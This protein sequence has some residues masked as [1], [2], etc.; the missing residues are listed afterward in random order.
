MTDQKYMLRF[1]DNAIKDSVSYIL[2]SKFNVAP[3]IL[4]AKINDNGGYMILSL[5]GKEGDVKAA[6][7]HL[8]GMGIKV[9]K[10][11]KQIT[12]DADK[13]IDCGSCISICPSEAFFIDRGTWE[14][15]LNVKSCIACASCLTACP[16]RAVRLT[17][18]C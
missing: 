17:L 7:K 1:D 15:K 2:V 4:Q 8:Q 13:C 9:R 10:L 16:T 5:N 6:I 3:S 12:R 11:A 18:P 14:V